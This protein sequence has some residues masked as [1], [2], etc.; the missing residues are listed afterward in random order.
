[1]NATTKEE[2]SMKQVT[3]I[4]IGLAKRSDL[5]PLIVLT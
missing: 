5:L 4:A 2:A 1:M 3:M